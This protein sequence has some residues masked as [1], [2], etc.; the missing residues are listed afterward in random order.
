MTDRQSLL[1]SDI[2]N[3]VASVFNQLCMNMRH[4][5]GGG[6]T[7]TGFRVLRFLSERIM[8]KAGFSLEYL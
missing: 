5:A 1:S 4:H 2:Q 3:G 8:E 7:A 6:Q